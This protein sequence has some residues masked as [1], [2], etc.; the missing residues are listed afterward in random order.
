MKQGNAGHFSV[1]Y[2]VRNLQDQI[3]T[4]RR[5]FV[6]YSV[7]RVLVIVT[8]VRSVI[9]GSWESVALCALSLVLFLLP[10]LAETRLNIEIPT[11]FEAIIYLFIFAAEILGEVNHYYVL[12]PGWDTMLHTLNGFLC[13]AVGYSLVDLFNKHSDGMRL[14]PKYLALVAFCFSMTVGVLWEFVEFAMDS[15][16]GVDMQKDFLV[17]SISSILLDPTGTQTPVR[18]DDIAQT[19]VTATDGQT[20]TI[21]GGYLDIGLLDTMK[22]LIVNFVGA[23]VF[24]TFGY[25][26]TSGRRNGTI[27]RGLLISRKGRTASA[28]VAREKEIA[29][30]QAEARAGE[31]MAAPTRGCAR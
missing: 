16:F 1:R 23:V 2:F 11:V 12:I 22:D 4:D 29:R 18:F 19:V 5:D 21:E 17:T 6:I 10:A 13:A 26:Y 9:I 14:S 31:A 15:L 30:V 20:L 28:H 3:R 27:V 25:L 24:C 8:L 7:L